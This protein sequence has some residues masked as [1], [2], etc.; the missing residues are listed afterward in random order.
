M[1]VKDN[2]DIVLTVEGI[3]AKSENY[4]IHKGRY[5][6]YILNMI[7]DSDVPVSAKELSE[8]SGIKLRA[9]HRYLKTLFETGKL[10]YIITKYRTHRYFEVGGAYD[11]QDV[12]MFDGRRHYHIFGG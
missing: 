7:K 4:K 12:K 6:Y 10:K 5:E 8:Q 2:N 3:P 9:V 11:K 1:I